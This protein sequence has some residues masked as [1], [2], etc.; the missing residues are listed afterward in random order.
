MD[1]SGVFAKK[2]KDDK[3]FESFQAFIPK[4]KV[5]DKSK[6]FATVNGGVFRSFCRT[7]S[8]ASRWSRQLLKVR[9]FLDFQASVPVGGP[10]YRDRPSMGAAQTDQAELA[11]GAK[12]QLQRI[13]QFKDLYSAWKSDT[14]NSR[15]ELERLIPQTQ[16]EAKKRRFQQALS[17]K[18][19]PTEDAFIEEYLNVR[20]ASDPLT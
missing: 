4:N 3:F 6:W 5:P 13:K 19:Q 12:D 14:I 17:D 2:D 7:T 20:T 18:P 1:F 10:S 15:A 11:F 8:A 16:D 9:K